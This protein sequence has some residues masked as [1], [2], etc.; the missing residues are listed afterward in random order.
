MSKPGAPVLPCRIF[1][2]VSIRDKA[3]YRWVPQVSRLRPGIP[4]VKAGT[5]PRTCISANMTKTKKYQRCSNSDI[6]R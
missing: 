3:T 1:E 4:L 6:P 5:V 2:P